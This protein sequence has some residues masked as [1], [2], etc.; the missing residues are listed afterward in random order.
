M[1]YI[2]A[3]DYYRAIKRTEVLT[4]ATTWMNLENTGHVK[5]IQSRKT[6]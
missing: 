1:W 2:H 4:H 6:L 5:K 3:K